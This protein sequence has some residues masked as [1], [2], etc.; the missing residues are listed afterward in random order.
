V[1][2]LLMGGIHEICPEIASSGMIH[3]PYFMKS[4]KVVKAILRFYLRNLRGCNVGI[5]EGGNI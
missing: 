5:T 3:I 1:L 4:G 2:V